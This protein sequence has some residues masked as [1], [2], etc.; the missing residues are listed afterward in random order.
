MSTHNDDE[1][2]ETMEMAIAQQEHLDAMR[3]E[4]EATGEC[5]IPPMSFVTPATLD[6]I[7]RGVRDAES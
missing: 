5:S 1:T 6:R 2:I 7:A 4:I 3:A